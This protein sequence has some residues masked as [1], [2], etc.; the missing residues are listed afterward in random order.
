M[1]LNHL[2]LTATSLMALAAPA[3]AVMEDYPSIKLQGLDKSVGRTVTFEAKVG[4]TIQYGPL[5]IK[6]HACRKAPP[7]EAPESAA[8]LQIWEVPPGAQ[9]SEWVFSGWM[10]ASSPALSAMDH[11]VYDV[12]V[13]DC[14]GREE[15]NEEAQ[16]AETSEEASQEGLP[17]ANA[18]NPVE[19]EAEPRPVTE[20]EIPV[21]AEADMS[22][23]DPVV[24]PETQTPVPEGQA[25]FDPYAPTP[26]PGQ[27][28]EPQTQEPVIDPNAPYQPSFQQET[29][30][31]V[32]VPAPTVDDP[33]TEGVYSP[34]QGRIVPVQPQNPYGQY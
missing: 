13:L 20:E 31:V 14:T 33:A 28:I 8:F 22:G 5:Y 11:A 19:N 27:A 34:S 3:H 15:P 21:D 29:T 7:I 32:P 6:I 17:A 1:R 2:L 25:P 18:E 4:S 23:D 30:P 26:Q 24:M 12:W 16:A 10:F 9:K